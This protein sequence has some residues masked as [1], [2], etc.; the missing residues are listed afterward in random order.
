MQLHVGIP[1]GNFATYLDPCIYTHVVAWTRRIPCSCLVASV[2]CPPSRVKFTT[3][4]IQQQ[5]SALTVLTFPL[6]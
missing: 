4:S 6:K 1:L 2:W 3:A 5:F